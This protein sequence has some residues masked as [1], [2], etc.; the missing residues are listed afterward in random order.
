MPNGLAKA[1]KDLWK[2]H[3]LWLAFHPVRTV[4]TSSLHKRHGSRLLVQLMRANGSLFMSALFYTNQAPALVG[5]NSDAGC[6]AATGDDSLKAV[7]AVFVLLLTS[8]AS[9][10]PSRA[11]SA[12]D[13]NLPISHQ[14][15]DHHP[16][17]IIF[18]MMMCNFMSFA[19]NSFYLLF[20]ASFIANVDV[21]V[22]QTW[23]IVNSI[24]ML[25]SDLLLTPLVWA[26]GA[27]LVAL[28]DALV[29]FWQGTGN[30][31]QPCLASD[32]DLP[33]D[34]LELPKARKSE[35][36]LASVLPTVATKSQSP[37]PRPPSNVHVHV[38]VRHHIDINIGLGPPPPGVN[39][40]DGVL[41]G[42][43][44]LEHL[45]QILA[46]LRGAGTQAAEGAPA[47][48]QNPTCT[49]PEDV[50]INEL[51]RDVA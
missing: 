25:V 21:Q 34:E 27:V 7:G 39:A 30:V 48:Q 24:S 10:G 8:L 11:L 14:A 40:F 36:T 46:E 5:A 1:E 49:V 22:V 32:L 9:E 12:L 28:V 50:A 4:L 18:K 17:K 15:T 33:Q 31:P 41:P 37:C 6:A 13:H 20:T 51:L 23:I 19:V 44:N 16:L 43:V 45:E 2:V 35:K 29:E 47:E 3:V 42:Q 38:T 26:I